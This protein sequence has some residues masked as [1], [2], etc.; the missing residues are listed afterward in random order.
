[1]SRVWGELDCGAEKGG[2]TAVLR[3]G[4]ENGEEL[5]NSCYLKRSAGDS[6]EGGANTARN[7]H[8]K[9]LS[10]VKTTISVPLKQENLSL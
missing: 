10:R 8:L 5:L 1:M 3:G 7:K 9:Y 4:R 2:G 6:R